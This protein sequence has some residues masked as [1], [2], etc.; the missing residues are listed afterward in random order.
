M[1]AVATLL[2][3]ADLGVEEF[4]PGDDLQIVISK[5]REFEAQLSRTARVKE[6]DLETVFLGDDKASQPV[7]VSTLLEPEFWEELLSLLQEFKD[8]FA[9]DYGDMKGLD[10]KFY[11]HRIYLRGRMPFRPNSKGIG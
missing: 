1:G 8:I 6:D 7:K 11:Q 3:N 5:E 9:W 2:K 10:P 4:D